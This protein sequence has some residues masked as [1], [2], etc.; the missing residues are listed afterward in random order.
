MQKIFTRKQTQLCHIV[1][2]IPCCHRERR[3]YCCVGGKSAAL[4]CSCG[5]QLAAGT[6][7]LSLGRVSFSSL[8]KLNSC[9]LC[10]VLSQTVC[11]LL[12]R[13]HWGR[14]IELADFSAFSD[15]TVLC[16][17]ESELRKYSFPFVDI[18]VI[19]SYKIIELKNRCIF[20]LSFIFSVSGRRKKPV[21]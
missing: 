15:K 17:G 1:Q 4:S 12:S 8:Y 7:P 10:S 20:V 11:C 13:A 19:W 9:V 5:P 14:N 21:A 3:C 18:V 16:V 2:G 6:L